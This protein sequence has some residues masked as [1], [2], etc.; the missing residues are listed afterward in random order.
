MPFD[1]NEYKEDYLYEKRIDYSEKER[2]PVGCCSWCGNPIYSEERYFYD[3]GNTY[4]CDF[5]LG[6]GTHEGRSYYYATETVERRKHSK[7]RR[8]YE[9]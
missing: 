1:K 4:Y 3:T 8:F 9:S 6:E 2:E 7:A 5:C